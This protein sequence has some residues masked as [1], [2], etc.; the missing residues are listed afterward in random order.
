MGIFDR[1]RAAFGTQDQPNSTEAAEPETASAAQPLAP[2]AEL[3]K[4]DAH[5]WTDAEFEAVLAVERE[6]ERRYARR[7]TAI[8][9]EEYLSPDLEAK[10]VTL[11]EAGMPNLRLVRHRGQLVLSVPGGLVS[12][13]SRTLPALGIYTFRVRGVSYHEQAIEAAS[14]SPGAKLRLV[15]EPENEFD[16]NA[17]AVHPNCGRGPLGYVNKQNAARI[18]R[19]PDAGEDLVA[20]TLSG[21]PRG[22]LGDPVTVLITTPGTLAHLRRT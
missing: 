7:S 4:R 6:D 21:S 16:P 18:A 13:R 5:T 9:R 3:R 14:L 8:R 19:R 20:I 12:F 15:R 2:V 22:S 17:I 10:Y 11:D 1:L